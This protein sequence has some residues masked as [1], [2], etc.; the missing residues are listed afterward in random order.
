M[1]DPN[2]F[3]VPP[4]DGAHTVGSSQFIRLELNSATARY[5]IRFPSGMFREE[6]STTELEKE[7]A[8]YIKSAERI[9]E[10]IRYTTNW[11][12]VHFYPDSNLFFFVF[13]DGR[14]M[15]GGL[16]NRNAFGEDF[17]WRRQ[18]E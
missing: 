18:G 13:P 2:P 17:I 16:G 9:E 12:R 14:E 10:V 6:I 5:A 1:R 15:R 7:L 8:R 4:L 3:N 11:R